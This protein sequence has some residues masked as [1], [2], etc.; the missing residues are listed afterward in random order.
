MSQL[1]LADFQLAERK[2]AEL[3]ERLAGARA[4]RVEGVARMDIVE[5]RIKWRLTE[6]EAVKTYLEAFGVGVRSRNTVQGQDLA[7]GS[8]ASS[9]SAGVSTLTRPAKPARLSAAASA[10]EPRIT[11]SST[12]TNLRKRKAPPVEDESAAPARKT[13]RRRVAP[14][15]WTKALDASAAPGPQRI[16][17]SSSRRVKNATEC[18]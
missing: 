4:R 16:V 9:S 13:S 14:V 15:P 10:P 2:L 8:A 12:L 6:I 1:T 3:K 18:Q 17:R 5:A 11:R 7:A